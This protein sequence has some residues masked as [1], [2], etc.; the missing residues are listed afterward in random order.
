VCPIVSLQGED[1]RG[2]HLHFHS[3]SPAQ[4]PPQAHDLG[5]VCD[6]L[7]R[8]RLSGKGYGEAAEVFA[9]PVARRRRFPGLQQ[10]VAG[11]LPDSLLQTVAY[12][13]GLF[14]DDDL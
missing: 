3:G 9:M 11:I 1:G 2:G 6:R 7:F 12:S 4:F 13:A 5:Q 8:F 10:F 14:P